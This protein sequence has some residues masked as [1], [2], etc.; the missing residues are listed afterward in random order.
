[1][2]SDLLIGIDV[3]STTVKAVVLE[4]GSH[5]LLFD[6]YVR[7][8]AR[9]AETL[10]V[11]LQQIR[12]QFP[13][14]SFEAAVCGSGGRDIAESMDAHFI[15]E[16]VANSLAVQNTYPDSRVAV[17]LG[18]QDAKIIFFYF[19]EHTEQLLASDMR[20]NGSCAGGTG[21]FIDEIA[22]LLHI[23]VEQFNDY[24]ARGSHIYDISGRCGVFAKTD[25]QPLLNQGVAREDIALSTFHA[26]AKQTIGGLAQG[27]EI[28]PPIIFEGGPLTFNP[29]LIDV[30][31]QRL[32]LSPEQIIR[33][34]KPEVLVAMG[35]AISLEIMFK[36]ER[37]PF[38]LDRGIKIL[39][40]Y[41]ESIGKK[42]KRKQ[43]ITFFSDQLEKESYLSQN[44][45]PELEAIDIPEGSELSVYVGIDAGSTTTKFVLIDEDEQLIDRSYHNN[46][47]DPLIVFK[48][49]FLELLEKYRKKGIALKIL[50]A[51]TTGYGE[52][53]FARA[54]QADHHMVE[55]VAHAEAAKKYA[56]E[57]SF[58]L[59]IGGQDMKAIRL[60]NGI[61]TGIT[62][63]EACSAGCGSFLEGFAS[64][65]GIPVSTIAEKAF[66]SKN[67]SLLGSRCTVFMNSSIITEQKNGKSPED[68]MAGLCRSII[69]N[70]FTKV[71]RTT[72]VASLGDMI[73]VQG[74]TFKNDAVLRAIEQ[75]TQK[76]VVRPPYPGEMGAI[77]IAMLT[78]TFLEEEEKRTGKRRESRFI[79]PEELQTFTFSKKSNSICPFCTNNCSRT[80][81]T[82]SNGES[83]VTGNRCEKGEIVG[84][85]HDNHIKDQLKKTIA[86]ERSVPDLYKEREKMLFEAYE[87]PLLTEKHN[88][89]LGIPRVLEFWSSMPFWSTFFT[90]LGFDLQYSDKSTRPTYERGLASVP[91]D[92]VCF[93][94]KLAHGHV[95]DLIDK[96]VDAIFFPVMG[97][98]PS[99]NDTVQSDFTCAVLKGY[100][101]I[102]RNS[103]EPEAKHKMR[104]LDP[105]FPWFD[106]RSR[107]LQ[108]INF[109]KETFGITKKVCRK[110]IKLGDIAMSSFQAKLETRG[111]EI[112]KYLDEK[113]IFGVVL[114]GR[115]YHNDHLVNHDLS[116]HF[117]RLGIPVLTI[118]CLPKIHDTELDK[119]R[120]D[121]VVN[122][123]VR[124]ISGAMFAARNS[125]LEFVQIVSFGCGH[126][127]VLSDEIIDVMEKISGK[128]PLVLKLDE[129]DVAGPLNVRIKSFIETVIARRKH[130]H[131]EEIRP[132]PDPFPVK[133]EKDKDREKILLIPNASVSFCKLTSA[134]LK[135]FGFR[136]EPLPL[137][138]EEGIKLAKKYTHNDVCYPAQINIGEFLIAM[139][140]GLYDPNDV[141]FAMGK[142][143]CDCRLSH[144]AIIA[145]QSMDQAGYEQVPIITNAIDEK[146]HPGATLGPLF[147]YLMV[148]GIVMFDMLEAI[149]RRIRP[150]ELN[151]GETDRVFKRCIDLIGKGFEKSKKAAI[152]AFQEAVDLMVEVP[153]DD[154]Y[155]KPRVFI[156]G[157]YLLNFHPASNNYIEDYMEKHGM[158]VVF[159]YMV[160][161]FRKDYVRRKAER[162]EFFV[163]YPLMDT[164]LN[165]VSDIVVQQALNTMD[166]IA[167]KHPAYHKKNTLYQMAPKSAH[168]MHR[169]FTSG[170]GWLIPGEIYDHAEEGVNS[171]IIL[172]PF[173]CLPNHI[174]GR[175]MVKRIK[176]D[177]PHVQILSLDYDPDTSAAN[178]ENRLQMLIINAR[179]LEKLNKNH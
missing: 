27:L 118:D 113:N 128:T 43:Q 114:G 39:E 17:E 74:G 31:A 30:F 86:K 138:D 47:G 123:H 164:I 52:R 153:F 137:I 85:I 150:Y 174:S 99:E 87:A 26:I 14:A 77:G 120:M 3:G 108:I 24:A 61:V 132:M 166:K 7:H 4:S 32:G 173:G 103:D 125:R 50:G 165:D 148:W 170:E 144:Y 134:I 12:E 42:Q 160:D 145:R 116:S 38:D 54:F 15:Q 72:N 65:L 172:Q 152:K 63:N 78:K 41:D 13:N 93:P 88:F 146:L 23:P 168:V 105:Y 60:E 49:A 64:S 140:R 91:S 167:R 29:V 96:K 18:G 75:Y 155:R 161:A 84:D 176:Q 110:A 57:V 20:M 55:T 9:Q 121:A 28:I 33:P 35:T 10:M 119:V 117:T 1:M 81:I 71:I 11:L 115:P 101:M 124:M 22:A 126:D 171:F 177:L 70:V 19:E 51:G 139:E 156:I 79:R 163:R 136:A 158:E 98:M 25:I 62:L 142:I 90:A 66:A 80:I 8:N 147:E 68:I 82:F 122:F 179:E 45:L 133:Y 6:T 102:I 162:R 67:P 37:R 40:D 36:K 141:A 56:P 178:V 83:F 151:P 149:V 94:A 127:A 21:A 97:R 159:P 154:S 92:T 109:M 76:R 143:T 59:D 46:Q 44:A 95:L 5:K 2:K 107:D 58:I 135:S 89:T 129:S 157:E 16:V 73:V 53:L 106:T 104:F 34:D 100:P 69:E 111:S 112:I 169:A 175:G 48:N 130:N 131:T